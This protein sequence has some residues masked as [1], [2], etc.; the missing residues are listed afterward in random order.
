MVGG[1]R[2]LA[3]MS[4]VAPPIPLP[5][6]RRV[7][8][9]RRGPMWVREITGPPGAPVVVLLHGWMATADLNWFTSYRALG[10][11]F[12]V[13]AVDHRG[14]GRGLRSARPFRIARVA[15]ARGWLLGL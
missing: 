11:H 15:A 13:L 5:P 7:Q 10:Q 6:G 8:L 2:R 4:D 1:R 3:L 9:P 12:R 14:H